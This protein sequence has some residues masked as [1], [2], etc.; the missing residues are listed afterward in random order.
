MRPLARTPRGLPWTDHLCESPQLATLASLRVTLRV[1]VQVL[2][3][4]YPELDSPPYTRDKP[5]HR[6][7]ARAVAR[8]T[9][10]ASYPN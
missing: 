10:V 1:F 5:A 2:D 9:A 8:G 6:R 4:P 7:P 3:I